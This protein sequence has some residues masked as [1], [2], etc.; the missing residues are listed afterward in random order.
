MPQLAPVTGITLILIP[1]AYIVVAIVLI[2]DKFTSDLKA[3]VVGGIMAK[4][5]PD[6]VSYW[7]NS[8]A[9]VAK[10]N[11]PPPAPS[12]VTTIVKPDEPKETS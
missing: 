7:L 6:I 4:T 11:D 9:D 12:T 1:L 5:L 8:S 10:K 3:M 2:S